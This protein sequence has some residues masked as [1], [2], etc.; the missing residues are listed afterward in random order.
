MA[1]RLADAGAHITEIAEQECFPRDP[2]RFGQLMIRDATRRMLFNLARKQLV[3]LFVVGLLALDLKLPFATACSGTDCASLGI[4]TLFSVL[5]DLGLT[6]ILGPMS[7][8]HIT[9]AE[10][11][12]KKHPFML[13]VQEL[14]G[15]RVRHLYG[16]IAHL[17]GDAVYDHIERRTTTCSDELVR[18]FLAGFSCIV[19][20]RLNPHQTDEANRTCISSGFGQT[21]ATFAG[22]RKFHD[23]RKNRGLF[24]AVLENV[25]SLTDRNQHEECIAALDEDG[26][27]ATS[28]IV[29][30]TA[31]GMPVCRD[32][33]YVP[34]WNK[35][36]IA[37]HGSTGGEVV[38]CFHTAMD[39]LEE[40]H[41][42]GDIDSYLLEETHPCI[43]Q[44]RIKARAKPRQLRGRKSDPDNPAKWVIK[45][46]GT[47]E[48][49]S[50]WDK[51]IGHR[52][53]EYNL[54]GARK[55]ALLDTSSIE[56]PHPRRCLIELSQDK[57]NGLRGGGRSPC[58][59]PGNCIWVAHRA[60]R[61]KAIE[62]M[63]LQGI[64]IPHEVGEQFG[65][66]SNLVKDLA[67]NAF[68]LLCLQSSVIA[69]IVGVGKIFHRK[70]EQVPPPL[71]IR[72]YSSDSDS[73]DSL[74]WNDL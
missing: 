68:N 45:Q 65:F 53:P 26:F 61:L 2:L 48:P 21:G 54:L 60:R 13:A 69:W 15:N 4:S 33:L 58:I 7:Y 52:F 50:N 16:D 44:A 43:L 8:P 27:I 37:E 74:E 63:N 64:W 55:Q 62:C 47:D 3:H 12:V 28:R 39:V 10:I 32:R 24:G 56:F 6:D 57:A 40:D 25:L 73:D 41:P 38:E 36:L 29:E 31:Y 70:F 22:T 67:G 51:T 18:F 11:D 19:V 14:S 34:T 23:V 30:P 46:K 20:S 59:T 66:D 35:S 5:A 71:S 72:K 42:L 17:T 9:A 49:T 1:T